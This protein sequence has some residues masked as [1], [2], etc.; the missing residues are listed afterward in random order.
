MGS[1][2]SESLNSRLLGL[3]YMDIETYLNVFWVTVTK[4]IATFP[5]V[6]VNALIQGQYLEPFSIFR[7]ELMQGSSNR[8]SW[9]NC[10][11]LTQ[12]TTVSSPF[13][14]TATLLMNESAMKA[15]MT[16]PGTGAGYLWGSLITAPSDTQ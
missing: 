5:Q 1:R 9:W 13:W 6:Q 14:R 10:M 11:P 15:Y 12:T 3:A 7:S 16:R 8:E 2:K 4:Q